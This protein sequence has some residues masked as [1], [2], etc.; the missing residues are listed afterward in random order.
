VWHDLHKGEEMIKIEVSD[1]KR[2]TWEYYLRKK[3][4][5]KLMKLE[6]MV[7]MLVLRTVAE[8]AK[9]E[10]EQLDSATST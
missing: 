9:R 7:E 10:L 1:Q 5:T 6:R 3:Y 4:N 2:R 8:E